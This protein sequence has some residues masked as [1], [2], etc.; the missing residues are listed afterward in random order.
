M[1]T[2][3]VVIPNRG[4]VGTIAVPPKEP[5]GPDWS[6]AWQKPTVPYRQVQ[7]TLGQTSNATYL[8]LAAVNALTND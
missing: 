6:N 5:P 2:S 4:L 7:W 3:E 1:T 8:N